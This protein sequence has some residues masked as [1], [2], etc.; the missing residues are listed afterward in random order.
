MLDVTPARVQMDW[1]VISSRADRAATATW[2]TSYE[3][4]ASAQKVRKVSQPTT[5]ATA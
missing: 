1:Y 4:P 3:V 2:S 5:G